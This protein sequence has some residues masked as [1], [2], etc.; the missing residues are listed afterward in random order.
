MVQTLFGKDIA[1]S[2]RTFR[3]SGGQSSSDQVQTISCQLYLE[4]ADDVSEEQAPDCSC[5]TA[6]ECQLMECTSCSNCLEKRDCG[7]AGI[8]EPE[9]VQNGCLWCPSCVQGEPW[10]IHQSG[11]SSATQPPP[12]V[13]SCNI[14]DS[15]KRDCG[16]YGI[17][18]QSCEA[19]GCCWQQAPC[20]GIPMCYF[21]A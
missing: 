20:D 14:D 8:T 15:A 16:Y 1:F 18:K 7:F 5:Y 9:C 10:C 11:D 12:G 4:S 3:F 2:I 19:D 21:P 6:E 17:N 13:A